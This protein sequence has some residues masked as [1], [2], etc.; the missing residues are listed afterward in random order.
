MDAMTGNMVDSLVDDEEPHQGSYQHSSQPTS[1]VGPSDTPPTAVTPPQQ[2][3]WSY[4]DPQGQVQGPFQSD[5]MLEWYNAG[6]FPPELMVKRSC[7][8]KFSNLTTL[9]NIYSRI[10]FTPGNAPPPIVEQEPDHEE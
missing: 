5:E 6:Y 9:T 10:P 2:M 8:T 7:D 4:L 3:T 1:G